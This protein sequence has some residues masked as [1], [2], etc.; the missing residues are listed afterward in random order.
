MCQ[1]EAHEILHTKG[2]DCTPAINRSLEHHAGDRT[3]WFVFHPNHEKE[4]PGGGQWPPNTFRLLSTLREDLQLV[5]YLEFSYAEKAV[6]LQTSMPSLG[7]VSR[8][9]S[10]AVSNANH[11]TG[12]VTPI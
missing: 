4:I 6:H 2:L 10:T 11:Y 9:Y 3:I 5:G 1:I 7:F 12:C 8:S